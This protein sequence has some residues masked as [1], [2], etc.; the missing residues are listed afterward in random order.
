[1]DHVLVRSITPP[2][3]QRIFDY[4]K[5]EPISFLSIPEPV[6]FVAIVGNGELPVL[7]SGIFVP[8]VPEYWHQHH[9]LAGWY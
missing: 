6:Y 7:P 9:G 4:P 5:G 1:M 3:L 2:R 8:E